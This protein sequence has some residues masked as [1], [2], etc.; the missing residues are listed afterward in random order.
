VGGALR[1][2]W[3]LNILCTISG[4]SGTI[5]H[6]NPLRSEPI[7]FPG[8]ERISTALSYSIYRTDPLA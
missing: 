6:Q 8:D 2:P 4:F 1:Q 3:H 7:Q 5:A